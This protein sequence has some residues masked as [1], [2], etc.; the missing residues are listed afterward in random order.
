MHTAIVGE[1]LESVRGRRLG[2]GQGVNYWVGKG[3]K[4]VNY[5]C[6]LILPSLGCRL[7]KPTE[8]G[9]HFQLHWTVGTRA[10]CV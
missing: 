4:Q 7:G 9:M 5:F 8:M 2:R 6:E 1:F 3:P 10:C